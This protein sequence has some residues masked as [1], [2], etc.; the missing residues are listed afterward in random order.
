MTE[1]SEKWDEERSG[2]PE[3]KTPP[4]TTCSEVLYFI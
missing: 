3:A 1:V 4:L 2:F